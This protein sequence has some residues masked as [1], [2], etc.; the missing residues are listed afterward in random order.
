MNKTKKRL[1]SY[2]LLAIGGLNLGGVSNAQPKDS[3]NT[4]NISSEKS[5]RS[6]KTSDILTARNGID[7]LGLLAIIF[8]GK[9]LKD[10]NDENKDL[11][12]KIGSSTT[13]QNKYDN[14]KNNY[15]TLQNSYDKLKN[16]HDELQNNY[17][18]LQDDYNLKEESFSKIKEKFELSKSH[19]YHEMANFEFLNTFQNLCNFCYSEGLNFFTCGYEELDLE[20]LKDYTLFKFNTATYGQ[21]YAYMS[22]QFIQR[23]YIRKGFGIFG[24]AYVHNSSSLISIYKYCDDSTNY[25]GGECGRVGIFKMIDGF[26]MEKTEH[27]VNSKNVII[28]FEKILEK[29]EHPESYFEG[30]TKFKN[31][32]KR[33]KDCYIICEAHR[34]VDPKYTDD[35]VYYKFSLVKKNEK[36]IKKEEEKEKEIKGKMSDESSDSDSD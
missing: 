8:G 19:N 24:D 6:F 15:D 27:K 7:V 29:I 3:T 2:L 4:S 28:D 10:K 5:K 9:K 25:F 13:L 30:S 11:R 14:L 1:L 16:S 34:V 36:G 26:D 23:A 22:A 17:D 33:F 32:K 31:D 18:E 35:G 20:D 21:G 12:L